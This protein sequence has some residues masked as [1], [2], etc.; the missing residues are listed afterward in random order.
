MKEKLNTVILIFTRFSTAIFLIDSIALFLF[1]GKEA[2]LFVTDIL[3]ILGIALLCG[4]LYVLL[5]DDRNLSKK[6]MFAMQLIYFACVDIIVLVTGYFLK[7]YSFCY[8][9][10]F[11]AFESVIISVCFVTILYSYK[12]DSITAKKMTEKLK[13]LED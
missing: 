11:Y 6:K 9:P 8:M 1:K 13:S 12:G 3:V 4:I 5:L 10:S 7:W 2:K